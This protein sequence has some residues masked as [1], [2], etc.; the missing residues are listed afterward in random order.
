M[1]SEVISS[2]PLWEMRL[3]GPSD[4]AVQSRVQ[5]GEMP[6]RME[7]APVADGFVRE[8]IRRLLVDVPDFRRG[9]FWGT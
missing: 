9:F 6:C 5:A 8:P 2:T 1:T 4:R 3:H 7:T